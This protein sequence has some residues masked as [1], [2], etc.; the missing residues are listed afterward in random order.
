MTHNLS[1]QTNNKPNFMSSENL[2]VL[3]VCCILPKQKNIKNE[4]TRS[5]S[6]HKKIWEEVYV[7][8]RVVTNIKDS[9]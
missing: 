7:Q 6:I 5:V 1:Q 8:K 2:F 9:F 4:M 3:A